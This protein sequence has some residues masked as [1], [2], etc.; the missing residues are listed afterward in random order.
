MY[1]AQKCFGLASGYEY[2]IYRYGAYSP[3]LANDYFSL[4]VQK[5][6]SSIDYSLTSFNADIFLSIIN[7][8]NEEWL[9][10]AT[11]LDVS[12]QIKDNKALIEQ[13]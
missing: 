11:L 9:E 13:V 12:S 6:R 7:N 1:L 3:D 8:K 5:M 2:N 10:V 4:D